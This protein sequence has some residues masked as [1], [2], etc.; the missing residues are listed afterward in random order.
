M[1]KGILICLLV[2]L[3]L[4]GTAFVVAGNF[5][6]HPQDSENECLEI[7]KDDLCFQR[8]V[9][10]RRALP[11]KN[12]GDSAVKI[13]SIRPCCPCLKMDLP[14]E[15][16]PAGQ[17]SLVN[18]EFDSSKA[19]PIQ[20][21]RPLR[22]SFDIQYETKAAAVQQRWYLEISRESK[23]NLER[24]YLE[25]AAPVRFGAGA[26]FSTIITTIDPV[27]AIDVQ[28]LDGFG[29]AEIVER[30][31]NVYV[32]SISTDTTLRP[33]SYGKTVWVHGYDDE[34]SVVEKCS[35][36]LHFSVDDRFSVLPASLILSGDNIQHHTLHLESTQFE[37]SSVDINSDAL[38]SADAV[39]V[40]DGPGNV[41][42][43]QFSNISPG[44]R[45]ESIEL[46]VRIKGEERPAF[47]YVPVVFIK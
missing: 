27:A 47:C 13:L 8:D 17:Q 14:L 34:G 2:S 38:F 25:L 10:F 45:H 37:I 5:T 24:T 4:P 43:L 41:L 12:V 29:T 19:P 28:G 9:S 3:G 36:T 44:L 31:K 15:E 23:I 22:L 21:D 6:P 33:D 26:K 16:I 20:D 39:I 46:I 42:T 30:E 35:L 11:I 1:F 32:V 18:V 40:P 7:D